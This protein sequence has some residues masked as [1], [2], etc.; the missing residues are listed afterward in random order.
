[1]QNLYRGSC[2]DKP[3]LNLHY[4][5]PELINT[6][7]RSPAKQHF[8]KNKSKIIFPFPPIP[9]ICL[10]PYQSTI[11]MSRKNIPLSS[12]RKC[13]HNGFL[14]QWFPNGYEECQNNRNRICYFYL[15][16]CYVYILLFLRVSKIF[17]LINFIVPSDA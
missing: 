4:S 10:I 9:V 7:L 5:A 17:S 3:V 13:N 8:R 15:W 11:H 12:A 14:Y 16:S 1:M 2:K 6:A